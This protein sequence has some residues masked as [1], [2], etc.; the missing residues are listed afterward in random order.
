MK[1]GGTDSFMWLGYGLKNWLGAGR[2]R[3][4]E[5]QA[6]DPEK[7]RP[8]RI[9]STRSHSDVAGTQLL[10]HGKRSG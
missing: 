9:P 3:M 5:M 6:R 4:E 7:E 10:E 8:K 1:P 2:E